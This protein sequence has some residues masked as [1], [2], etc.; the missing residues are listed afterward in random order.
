MNAN[1]PRARRL[2]PIQAALFGC[3]CSAVAAGAADALPSESEPRTFAPTG[4]VVVLRAPAPGMVRIPGGPFVMGSTPDEVLGAAALCATEPLGH[5]CTEQT[6]ANELGRRTLTLPSFWIDRT[7]VTVRDYERCAALGQCPPAA[8]PEGATRLLQPDYPVV[9][10]T[11]FGA[12]AYCRFR[13]ARLPSEREF[14][15]AARGTRGRTFPWGDAYNAHGA[16]HG[17]LALIENDASDGFG[18][19]APVGSFAAGATPEGV[20]DLAG[21]VAEWVEDVY[22]ERYDD[23]A[24][25]ADTGRRTVRGGSFRSAAAW[26]RGA[27]RNGVPP[28]TVSPEIGFRCARSAESEEESE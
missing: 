23:P 22:R 3:L 15:R 19:L 4:E 16:N 17:R 11:Y 8:Y 26:I 5:R 18:E 14:E 10:V 7:E 20:L 12:R 1:L 27:A 21:N 13:G 24:T 2:A 25:P 9:F 6:F 28:E